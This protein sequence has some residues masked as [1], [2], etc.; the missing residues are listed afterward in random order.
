MGTI[1]AYILIAIVIY[2]SVKIIKEEDR[3]YRWFSELKPGDKVRVRIYSLNC[4]CQAKATV[5][6]KPYLKTV[7]VKL[8]D[9]DYNR[10]K[11]CA[12]INGI[13][14]KGVQTCWYNVNTIKRGDI[15]K[16]LV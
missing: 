6:E 16:P 5:T 9:Q 7:E 4:D 10:C 3:H 15:A 1:I 13:T 8:D 2:F 12:L 11:G 14:P